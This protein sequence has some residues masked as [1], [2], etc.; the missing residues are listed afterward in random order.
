M[1]PRSRAVRDLKS[2]VKRNEPREIVL[3]MRL[4]QSDIDALRKLA[5]QAGCGHTTVARVIIEKY[6]DEHLPGRRAARGR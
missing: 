2:L 1:P 6:L 5:A 3:T 4:R